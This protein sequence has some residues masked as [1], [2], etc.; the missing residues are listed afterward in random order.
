MGQDPVIT[1]NLDRFASESLVF[2][3]AVSN[4][5][6]C[7][8]YRG[9]LFSG[10]YPFSNHVVGNCNDQTAKFGAELS[11]DEG[12]F[13]DVLHDAGYSQGYNGKLHLDLPKEEDAPFTE[14]VKRDN[15][16]FSGQAKK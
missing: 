13:S 10:K 2:T 15:P 1:P 8:P 7:S 5:P 14:D 6:V 11:A 12:C 4:Y 3:H 9:M 16:M